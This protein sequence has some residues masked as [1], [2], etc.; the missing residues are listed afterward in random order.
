MSQ[1]RISIRGTHLLAGDERT[2]AIIFNN[3]T[4]KN[5]SQLP[6]EPMPPAALS[7]NHASYLNFMADHYELSLNPGDAVQLI[8]PDGQVIKTSTIGGEL[9]L[10]EPDAAN[11]PFMER[12]V[13]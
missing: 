12:Q 13:G 11:E 8:G 9:V 10:E 3:L 6:G 5:F 4:G 2:A 1:S 7:G